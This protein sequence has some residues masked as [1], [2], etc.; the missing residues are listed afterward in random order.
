MSINDANDPS[1][2]DSMKILFFTIFICG[3]LIFYVY[4]GFLTSALAIPS[5]DKPFDSPEGILKTSYR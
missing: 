3:S 5:D 4:G 2:R 1:N